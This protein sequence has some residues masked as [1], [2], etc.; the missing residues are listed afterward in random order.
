MDSW[1]LCVKNI[2]LLFVNNLVILYVCGFI[3]I[4]RQDSKVGT[5]NDCK[6]GKCHTW[7]KCATSDATTSF[8]I[9]ACS[10][11]CGTEFLVHCVHSQL[12]HTVDLCLFVCAC[13]ADAQCMLH[14]KYTVICI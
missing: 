3:A 9:F 14:A 4:V 10:A 8:I 1:P 7:A 6:R 12:L 5:G 2:Y 13:C 11:G